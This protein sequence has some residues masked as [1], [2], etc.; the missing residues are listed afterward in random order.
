MNLDTSEMSQVDQATNSPL[1]TYLKCLRIRPTVSNLEELKADLLGELRSYFQISGQTTDA[2]LFEQCLAGAQTL[3]QEWKDRKVDPK[4]AEAVLRFYA[5]TRAYCYELVG[6]DLVASENR[7]RQLKAFSTFLAEQ[8]AKRGLDFG[9]GIGSTGITLLQSGFQCEFAD[10]SATNLEFIRLRLE[11]RKLQAKTHHLPE[12]T[13]PRGTYDFILAMD[14]LENVQDPI[15]KIS[16]LRTL[17][18]PG[19]F[20]IFNLI[21]GHHGNDPLHLMEDPF[22]VRKRIRQLGF[23][24]AHMIGEFKVYQRVERPNLVNQA[25]GSLDSAFWN[26]R[27]AIKGH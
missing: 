4:D 5:V 15:G 27:A 3:T 11:N 25:L 16:E 18:K 8:G 19:G 9:S 14:V 12:A 22:L 26:V 6:L 7:M 24:K 17:L 2:Q 23:R 10:V 20:L 21:A 1:Q 13:L